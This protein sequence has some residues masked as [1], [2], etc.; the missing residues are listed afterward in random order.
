MKKAL[1]D[2]R[3][4]KL[5]QRAERLRADVELLRTEKDTVLE[6]MTLDELCRVEGQR[7]EGQASRLFVT[8]LHLDEAITYLSSAEEFDVE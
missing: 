7:I 3:I 1:K 5:K 8:M 2:E 4:S 6:K